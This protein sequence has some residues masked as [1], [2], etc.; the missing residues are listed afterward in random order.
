VGPSAAAAGG[1]GRRVDRSER[2]WAGGVLTGCGRGGVGSGFGLAVAGED[3]AGRAVLG[4]VLF[5]WMVDE[6]LLA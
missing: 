5:A 3:C 2:W 4:V 1:D 6:W